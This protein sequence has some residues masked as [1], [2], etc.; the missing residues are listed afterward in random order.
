[1]NIERACINLTATLEFNIKVL[2]SFTFILTENPLHY[3][4]P[5]SKNYLNTSICLLPKNYRFLELYLKYMIGT[6]LIVYV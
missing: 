5:S 1:M 3:R 2:V 6:H 4:A